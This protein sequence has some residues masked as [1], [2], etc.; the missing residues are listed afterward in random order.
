MR[1]ARQRGIARLCHFTPSRNL[2]HILADHHGVLATKHLKDDDRAV[3][4][5]TDL[6]RLDGHPDHVC[7]SIQYP[8]AWY[9]Q[10]ARGKERLF[11]DWAVLFIDAHYLWAEGTKFSPLNASAG[12]GQ[13]LQEGADAFDALFVGSTTDTK[14]RPWRRGARHPSYLP[15]NEQAEVLVLDQIEKEDLL[16]VAV[17]D[18]AQARRELAALRILDVPLPRIWVTPTFYCPRSLSKVLRSG[19]QPTETEFNG[20]EDD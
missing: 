2:G 19:Q 14:G 16:G 8:N 1:A 11:S 7:C 10:K 13:Y 18:E 9:F 4:N 17:R 5:A 15:T 3:L 12:S 20:G 6:A